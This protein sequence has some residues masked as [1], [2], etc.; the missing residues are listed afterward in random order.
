VHGRLGGL[1]ER[2]AAL[3]EQPLEAAGN[4]DDQRTRALGEPALVLSPI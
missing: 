4:D 1:G 2:N 3:L